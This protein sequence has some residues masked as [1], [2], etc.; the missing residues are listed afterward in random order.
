MGL[1]AEFLARISADRREP[2]ELRFNAG[3]IDERH[4]FS[5]IKQHYPGIDF[6][7][8]DFA[9]VCPTKDRARANAQVRG[10]GFG[11]AELTVGNAFSGRGDARMRF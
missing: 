1:L 9:L 4:D 2:K 7:T 10:N 5:L 8:G 6:V 3:R 11:F